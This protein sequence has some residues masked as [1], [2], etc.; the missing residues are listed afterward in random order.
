MCGVSCNTI[1]E[2]VATCYLS[3]VNTALTRN[4]THEEQPL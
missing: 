2:G 4:A 1:L 3:P